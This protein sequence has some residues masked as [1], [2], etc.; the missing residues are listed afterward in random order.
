MAHRLNPTEA[1]ALHYHALAL[2]PDWHTNR[3][4]PTWTQVTGGNGRD[5]TLYHADNYAHAHA[6]LTT[7]ATQTDPRMRTPNLYPAEG[8]HWDTTRPHPGVAQ[9]PTPCPDHPYDP[10]G[11]TDCGGCWADI[12]AGD[13]PPGMLG[14]H[15]EVQ[16]AEVDETPSG[17]DRTGAVGDDGG[18]WV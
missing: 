13:R 5:I 3:P 17:S 1:D 6:A 10:R 8:T 4:G 14:Q 9:P 18:G 15:F 12:K 11:A 2:R 16:G 7:Y